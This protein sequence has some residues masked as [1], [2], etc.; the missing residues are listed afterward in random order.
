MTRGVFLR[1]QFV[2]VTS[3][4]RGGGG[5][6]RYVN[7]LESISFVFCLFKLESKTVGTKTIPLNEFVYLFFWTHRKFM[8]MGTRTHLDS[9]QRNCLIFVSS[10]NPK[11]HFCMLHLVWILTPLVLLYDASIPSPGLLWKK[12]CFYPSNVF[13]IRK[14]N[15]NPK[16]LNESNSVEQHCLILYIL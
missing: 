6:G 11:T 2:A 16:N 1:D 12:N 10:Y 8:W 3:S 7:V 15:V 13:E 5:R 14:D 9:T 4:R